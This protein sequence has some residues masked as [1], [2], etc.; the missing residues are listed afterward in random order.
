MFDGGAIAGE[1][2]EG[3]LI[4]PA[5]TGS[6]APAPARPW[7]ERMSTGAHTHLHQVPWIKAGFTVLLCSLVAIE[8][9]EDSE[10]LW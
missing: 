3:G 7:G 6:T 2:E 4:W 9:T 10:M 1:G 8:W 5:K